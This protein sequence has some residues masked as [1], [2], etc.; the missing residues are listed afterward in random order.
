MV[1]SI[2]DV[3]EEFEYDP[4]HEALFKAF[5]R[6][7]APTPS[8]PKLGPGKQRL[9]AGTL[10]DNGRFRVVRMIKAGGMGAVYEVADRLLND[11]TFALKEMTDL[12]SDPAERVAARDR[13]ISEIQVMQTL[14]HPNIPRITAQFIHEN[15]FFFVME[16]IEGVDLGQ[17]LKKEGAPGLDAQRV[18]TWS[19]QVLDALIYTHAQD[20]PITHRDI[21]PSNVLLSTRDERV[22]LIDFGISRV[23][24]MGDGFW[25][26]TPGYAPAE[27]QQNQPGPSSD[28][29]ALGASMHEMLTGRKPT[30]NFEWPTFEQLG[31][32]VD[33]QLARIIYDSLGT[34]PEERIATAQDMR[35]RLA[36]LSNIQVFLPTG[37]T[38]HD[39]EAAAHKLKVE[40]LDPLLQDL[41]ARY[42]N[43]CHTPHIPK[44]LEFLQFTL[45]CPTAYELQVV[46]DSDGGTILFMEK[47]GILSPQRLGTVNP[48]SE[49]ASGEVRTLIA[50]FVENYES[51]KRF[52]GF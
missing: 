31:V 39:F 27:Q 14:R 4:N 35:D 47:Q 40:V 48:L 7:E 43:E 30:D 17:V 8:V 21:K 5:T 50:Q 36:N 44:N 51:F 18:V 22:W 11:R 32:K 49:Q 6:E 45:A 34:W 20:P 16:F 52:G 41:I 42:R 1:N 13:F 46:K 29:Y 24:G 3:T 26:G 25:I 23:A 9:A 12:T 38:G 15:S 19:L 33:P 2:E 37:P 10:L 28:L